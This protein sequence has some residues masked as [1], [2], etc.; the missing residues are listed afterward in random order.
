MVNQDKQV[1]SEDGSTHDTGLKA[2]IYVTFEEGQESRLF[3]KTIIK[4]G[5]IESCYDNLSG[6]DYTLIVNPPSTLE[7][8][9]YFQ[10]LKK[11]L[12]TIKYKIYAFGSDQL[13]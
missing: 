12:P 4:D 11:L 9:A 8:Y 13:K 2:H 6:Y 3:L 5:I 7:L 1:V 10:K